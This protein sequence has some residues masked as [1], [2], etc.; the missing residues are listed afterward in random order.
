MKAKYFALKFLHFC[1]EIQ[2]IQTCQSHCTAWDTLTSKPWEICSQPQVKSEAPL[3]CPSTINWMQLHFFFRL[4][5]IDHFTK[6]RADVFAQSPWE[7]KI[8]FTCCNFQSDVLYK[9]NTAL[10]LKWKW[11]LKTICSKFGTFFPL[12]KHEKSQFSLVLTYMYLNNSI[13]KS[14]ALDSSWPFITET[15]YQMNP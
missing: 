11:E 9:H 3:S 13:M 1:F 2:S 6:A 5:F 7:L 8:Y 15:W 12:N 14:R 10:I 4:L